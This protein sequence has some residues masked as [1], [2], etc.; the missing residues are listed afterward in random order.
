MTIVRARFTDEMNNGYN[1]AKSETYGQETEEGS[2]SG[3]GDS[4]WIPVTEPAARQGSRQGYKLTFIKL[5]GRN[6]TEERST[7]LN[8]LPHD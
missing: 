2:Y 7:L 3:G 5:F 1:D 6:P 8:S 4:E